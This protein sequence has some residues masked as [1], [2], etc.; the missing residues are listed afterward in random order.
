MKTTLEIADAVFRAAKATAAQQGRPLRELVEEA[1]REK[2]ESTGGVPEPS[3]RRASGALRHLKFENLQ[4]G[5]WIEE[6]FEHIEPEDLERRHL[7]TPPCVW[8]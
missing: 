2:L 4:I 7:T 3:W 6:E 8:V 5:N 1:L